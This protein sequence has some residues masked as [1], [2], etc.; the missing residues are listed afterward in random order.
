MYN[1]SMF[2][3]VFIAIAVSVLATMI[4]MGNASPVIGIAIFLIMVTANEVY[5]IRK[6]GDWERAI[7]PWFLLTIIAFV[8]D[9]YFRMTPGDN[10]LPVDVWI[11]IAFF[12]A[13]VIVLAKRDD[14]LSWIRSRPRQMLDNQ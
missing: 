10:H 9:V 3:Y 12:I 11:I 6:T 2:I 4:G 5:T 8:V 7:I 14:V 1:K 13:G